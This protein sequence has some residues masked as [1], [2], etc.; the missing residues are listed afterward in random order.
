MIVGGR[1]FYPQDIEAAVERV[2]GIIAGRVVAFGV[3]DERSGTE[4]LVV[5]AESERP[6]DE[7]LAR[8]VHQAVAQLT[9]AAPREVRIVDPRSL[10]KSSSGKLARGANRD[11]Y[12]EDA[13]VRERSASTHAAG[14]ADLVAAIRRQV[15][16]LSA[17]SAEIGDEEPILTSGLIDSL[18]MAELLDFIET[19]YGVRVPQSLLAEPE[20]LDT[21]VG[22]RGNGRAAARRAPAIGSPRLR[23]P[24][25]RSRWRRRRLR[26]RAAPNLRGLSHRVCGFA[27]A[28]RASAAVCTCSAR[29]C[30]SW[31]GTRRTSR[32]ER[33]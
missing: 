8:E 31:T 6:G 7:G 2:E 28:A 5:L 14:D 26:R 19:T 4:E 18:R 27:C 13:P 30:Y 15:A 33:T 25:A 21:V 20:R 11:R 32:L 1:N 22:D 3:A 10:L 24:S 17:V 29:C 23:L 16:L 12:L 9:E